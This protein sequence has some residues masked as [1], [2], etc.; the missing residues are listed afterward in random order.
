MGGK[1]PQTI[2]TDQCRAMEV[3]IAN[4]WKET[5]HRW[6]KWHVLKRV[7][8]CVGPKYT[9]NRDF[10]DRFHKMLNE[11]LTEEEFVAAWHMLVSEYG[12]EDNAFLNSIFA[13]KEKWVKCYFKGVF[14]ARMSTTQHSES[15]NMMLKNIV[16]PSCPLNVF[17]DQYSK[18]QYIRD[19]EENYQEKRSKTEKKKKPTGGPLVEHAT[20]LYTPN[21]LSMFLDLKDE[22]EFYKTIEISP[23]EIYVAEHYDVTRVERWC[24]GRYVVTVGSEGQKHSCECGLFEHFGLPCSHIIRVMV[25]R[26]AHVIPESMIMRRWTKKARVDLPGHMAVYNRQDPNLQS[27][28][29]RHSSL[30]ISALEYVEMADM[31]PE[32][33][34]IGLKFLADGKKAMQ[35]ARTESDGLGLAAR[36]QSCQEQ[37]VPS[38]F[39]SA[40]LQPPKRRRERGRPSNKRDKAGY[41]GGSK[42]PRVC[43]VCK[44]NNHDK[45]T[46]PD[47][48]RNQD[49]PRKEPTCSGCG[50]GGHNISGCTVGQRNLD[51]IRERLV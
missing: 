47:R 2:L 5:V 30:M 39:V 41:E 28:S 1:A 50:L 34:T 7:V 20:E 16:P 18:L 24:K 22:L 9:Q 35:A 49:A 33:Y 8:E 48:D 29:Y 14:C 36:E 21:V 4:V 17:V 10:R 27:Q 31:N 37:E 46:C 45:Q 19:E 13:V 23:G 44:S 43:S 15:A 40:S 11:M 12:L 42:R 26:C 25:T 3:A 32:C 51:V 6:C 38:S